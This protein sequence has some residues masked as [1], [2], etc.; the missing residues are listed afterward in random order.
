VKKKKLICVQT[1]SI[2]KST[3]RKNLFDM[4]LIQN[5]LKQDDA[6]LLLLFNF[7]LEY[8][9]KKIPENQKGLE[10]NGTHITICG[11]HC[12]FLSTDSVFQN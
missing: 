10:L 3:Y 1:K 6:L 8:A 9:M 4:F 12:N 7:A 11:T 2:V 5:G